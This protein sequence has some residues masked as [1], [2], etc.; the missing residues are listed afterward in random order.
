MTKRFCDKCGE[1]ASG[2]QLKVAWIDPGNPNDV[3]LYESESLVQV[4]VFDLCR[5]CTAAVIEVMP[6]KMLRPEPLERGK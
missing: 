1:E 2:R 5:R 4:Q 6:A 3:H